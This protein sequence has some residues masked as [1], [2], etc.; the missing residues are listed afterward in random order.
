MHQV[1]SGDGPSIWGRV[2]TLLWVG[3][4]WHQ[5]CGGLRRTPYGLYER[6]GVVP[7]L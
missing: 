3:G 5:Q 1:T 6:E 2:A 7:K 4:G